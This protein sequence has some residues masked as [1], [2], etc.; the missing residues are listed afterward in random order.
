MRKKKKKKKWGKRE[1]GF[2]LKN[3]KTMSNRELARH[4]GV[5]QKSIETKL[6]R[7]GVK[8]RSM[9]KEKPESVEPER[10]IKP[11]M[12]EYRKKAISI[13]DK[14]VQ[15]Y[16]QGLKKEALN[17]FKKV[18]SDHPNVIDVVRKAKEYLK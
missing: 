10:K 9:L 2:L 12:D 4:F 16:C 11:P 6:H 3:Y 8:R 15:L 1:D 17:E 14:G 13:F 18:V 7:L 5:T